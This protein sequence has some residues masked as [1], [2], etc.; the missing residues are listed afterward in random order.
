VERQ[1]ITYTDGF[2]L[3][4][5]CLSL[6]LSQRDSLISDRAIFD[7]EPPAAEPVAVAVAVAPV[8]ED[9]WDALVLEQEGLDLGTGQWLV[10]RCREWVE[11]EREI[12]R[13]GGTPVAGVARARALA[14]PLLR[15]ADKQCL[16]LTVP[17]LET[18]DELVLAYRKLC[19]VLG[20][21][22]C[23]GSPER[24]PEAAEEEGECPTCKV[25]EQET[26]PSASAQSSPSASRRP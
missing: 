16:G 24:A 20:G 1:E 21:P 9:D 6:G 2:D 7:G 22:D 19:R 11:V 23:L 14:R 12:E 10:Q 18:L 26:S 25:D 4:D 17:A 8:E 15:L 13:L 5:Q 3:L